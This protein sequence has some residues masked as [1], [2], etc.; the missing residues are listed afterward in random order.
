MHRLPHTIVLFAGALLITAAYSCS[1][2]D[3]FRPFDTIVTEDL[4]RNAC[5]HDVPPF[6]FGV[7]Q[8][9]GQ[10]VYGVASNFG[11]E[12][13][14]CNAYVTVT[15]CKAG[16]LL[17]VTEYEKSKTEIKERDMKNPDDM[18][19]EPFLLPDIGKRAM[20]GFALG[21]GGGGDWL[22]FTTSD[23]RYDVKVEQGNRLSEGVQGP[24]VLCDKIARDICTAYDSR[25]GS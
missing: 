13:P 9:D 19:L 20:A 15:V 14:E 7:K 17:D 3:A 18:R 25:D 21:P 22:I 2:S 5:K 6:S 8:A 23:G 11:P 16:K 24:T 4:V 12:H 1:K 10:R